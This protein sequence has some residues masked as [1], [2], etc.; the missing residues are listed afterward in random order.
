MQRRKV[1][2]PEPDGPTMHITSRGATSR[3][4][5]RSTSRRPYDLWTASARTIGVAHQAIITYAG[6]ST[7]VGSTAASGGG[8]CEWNSIRRNRCSGVSGSWRADPRAKYRSR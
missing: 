5:P 6:C 4:M 1:L 7:E 3:S 2:L 8:M